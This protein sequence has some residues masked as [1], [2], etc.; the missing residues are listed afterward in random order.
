MNKEMQISV[1]K[2]S[3]ELFKRIS[4]GDENHMISPLSVNIALAMLLNGAGEQTVESFLNVLG[5]GLSKEDYQKELSGYLKELPVTEEASLQFANSIWADK[6]IRMKY[7]FSHVNSAQYKAFSKRLTFDSEA[8]E[9]INHWVEKSTDGM[10]T[11][12]ID[13]LSPLDKL[14]LINALAFKGNWENAFKPGDVYDEDFHN[15]DGNVSVVKGMHSVENYYLQNEECT[16]FVKPYAGGRY[17]FAAFLPNEGTDIRAFEEAFTA[18]KYFRLIAGAL[19][20][21]TDVM[22]PKFTS[23]FETAMNGYLSELG[24]DAFISGAADYSGISN[25]GVTVGEILHKTF[26]DVNETGTRAAAVT[27]VLMKAMAMPEP[28]PRVIL[29]RPFVYAVIDRKYGIPL[30]IGDVIK[31]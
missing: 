22:L 25:F 12:I 3:L 10:I 24:L 28:N 8:V 20:Q 19:Q 14:V 6:E 21:K 18:E 4:Q 11:H 17:A 27:A 5:N 7:A 15:A 1:L 9:R 26:I 23:E 2:F 13:A 29:D 30:F 31:L 16:G